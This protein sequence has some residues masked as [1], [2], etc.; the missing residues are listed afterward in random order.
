M[1]KAIKPRSESR[2]FFVSLASLFLLAL[3]IITGDPVNVDPGAIIDALSSGELGSI[4]SLF[5]VNLLNPI[6]KLIG[7]V[8][9][10]EINSD[11]LKSP[12]FITQAVTALLSGVSILGIVFPADAAGEVV[13]AF[14]TSDFVPIWVALGINI[15]NPIYHFIKDKKNEPEPLPAS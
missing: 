8:Q 7:K 1:E 14:Y 3:A 11:F 12:N 2:N 6:M 5:F 13:N 10:G 9:R 4:I 15:L